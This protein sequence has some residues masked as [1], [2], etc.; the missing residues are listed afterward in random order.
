[1][2]ANLKGHVVVERTGV[3]LLVRDAQFREKIEN[4]VGL[5]FEFAS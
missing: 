3:R 5:D 1:M 2:L 4:H